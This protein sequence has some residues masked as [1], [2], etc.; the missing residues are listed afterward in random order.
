MSH[1]QLHTPTPNSPSL[2]QAAPRR[3]GIRITNPDTHEPVVFN[4]SSASTTPST[5]SETVA[6][7]VSHAES[8]SESVKLAFK[9]AIAQKAEE[10]KLEEERAA[11]AAAAAAKE[12]E[13]KKAAEEA[14]KLKE[15]EEK[16]AA[17]EA[18]AKKAEEEKA[19]EEAAAKQKE[20]DEQKAAEEADSKSE[21]DKSVSEEAATAESPEAQKSDEGLN[22]EIEA[23]IANV[24][25]RINAVTSTSDSPVTNPLH[26]LE[27]AQR[28]S[29]EEVSSLT[30]PEGFK[31]PSIRSE[32][33]DVY[34]YDLEFLY[35]F[36]NVVTFPPKAQWETIQK[37]VNIDKGFAGGNSGSGKGPFSRNNSNRN[38]FNNEM[39]NF[40]IRGDRSVSG[41]NMGGFSMSG[42]SRLGSVTNLNSMGYKSGRQNSSRRRGNDRSGSNRGNRD[43]DGSMHSSHMNHRNNTNRD[44]NSG[45]D[46][47]RRNGEGETRSEDKPEAPP[48]TRSANAWVPRIRNSAPASD[49]GKLTPEAV[50]RKVK[51]LLNKMTLDNFDIITDELLNISNQ[52]KDEKDGRTLRQV[53]ELTFAKAVD[54]AHWSN[55]YARFCAKMLSKAD[56]EIHDETILDSKG[57]FVKGGSLFRKYLLSRCQ[58]EFER[59]WSDKLPTNPD[60]T[61]LDPELMSDEYYELM[62]AKR[63]GLGLIR[64]IGELYFLEMLTEKIIH[65]CIRRLLSSDPPSEE[66]IESICQLMTTVGKNLEYTS[67]GEMDVYMSKLQS[68][69]EQE[70]LPSRL[71]FM[72]MDIVDLRK[73]GWDSGAQDKGPKTVAEIH[74]E[75]QAKQRE[76]EREKNSQGKRNARGRGPGNT[77]SSSDFAQ[78]RRL[79]SSTPRGDSSFSR[80]S[81]GRSNSRRGPSIS[82]PGI[83]LS[84]SNSQ[85]APSQSSSNPFLALSE[86]NDTANGD[87]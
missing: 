68:I 9:A 58:E 25:D 44:N 72:I 26:L 69:Q 24:N 82:S 74:E 86:E 46:G 57:Q 45:A 59:G 63:H 5:I 62:A 2:G 10:Q 39:G 67:K 27:K 36:Q 40:S 80:E 37:H 22:E 33:Q 61:P 15:E 12:E 53:I 64:F 85:R 54:E 14:A 81:S 11:A 20:E 6:T 7:P 79:G 35:Q 70:T 32:Q 21:E 29:P 23:A 75:A 60:G 17:E 43:R 4:K 52:S 34:L 55:M 73:A 19:A 48:L 1:H 71:R 47:S 65:R 28:P 87:R 30:Y 51:S 41:P 76:K 83:P 42:K 31:K 8:E 50:Q 3:G 78:L 77:L 38:A 66:V 84:Q 13:E 49:D 56:P 16:K 18:A